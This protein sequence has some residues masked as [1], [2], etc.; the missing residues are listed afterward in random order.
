MAERL[1]HGRFTVVTL[2]QFLAAFFLATFALALNTTGFDF[3]VHA[4]SMMSWDY[5]VGRNRF[6]GFPGGFEVP[7][8]L[9]GHHILFLLTFGVFPLAWVVITLHAALLV[10]CIRRLDELAWYLAP[11]LALFFAYIMVYMS[12]QGI[13]AAFLVLAVLSYRTGR[14]WWPW[15]FLGA[16]FHPVTLILA[17]I[18]VFLLLPWARGFLV[19]LGVVVLSLLL[20]FSYPDSVIRG[21]L[22]PF[23]NPRLFTSLVGSLT[24]RLTSFLEVFAIAAITYGMFRVGQRWVRIP[25]FP[26]PGALMVATVL[27]AGAAAIGHEAQFQ[28]GGAVSYF[29]DTEYLGVVQSDKNQLICAAWVSRSCYE[30][31]GEER[32]FGFRQEPLR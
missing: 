14:I 13:G 6:W 5:I 26:M 31:L 4:Q 22:E 10:A 11:L 1:V 8:Y 30:G 19:L 3:Y 20:A 24:S 15:L 25:R 16:A 17:T 32:G 21:V 12:M 2:L 28:R 9:L 27:V 7:R 18:L 29:W 23:D